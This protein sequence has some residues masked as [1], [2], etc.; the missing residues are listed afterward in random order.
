MIANIS[1][2]YERLTD[3]V[4]VVPN[5]TSLRLS[6]STVQ[7]SGIGFVR[8]DG[9]FDLVIDRPSTAGDSPSVFFRA[10]VAAGVRT[11]GADLAVELVNLAAVNG[12]VSGGASERFIHT[13]AIGART[14]GENQFHLGMVFP[15]DDDV[16]GD[17]WIIS[18]GYTRT[19]Y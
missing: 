11:S 10:N 19:M 1:T 5:Y 13:A 14:Q 16:R 17:I 12:D 3:F 9:G 6:A 18:F 2:F 7:Q 4:V 15:L 8:A